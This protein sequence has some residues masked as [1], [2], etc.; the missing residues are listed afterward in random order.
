MI[1]V[2]GFLAR[3]QLQ[4]IGRLILMRGT[5]QEPT[6]DQAASWWIAGGPLAQTLLPGVESGLPGWGS[7]SLAPQARPSLL[8]KEGKDSACSHT[9]AQLLW[10]GT[11]AILAETG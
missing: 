7:L 5:Q 8:T 2:P 6:R 1:R 3:A 11:H 4:G 9:A 10:G